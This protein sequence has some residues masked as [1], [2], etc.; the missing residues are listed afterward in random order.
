[1]NK[2]FKKN[3]SIIFILCSIMLCIFCSCNSEEISKNKLRDLDFT[4]VEQEDIPEELIK[5]IDEK[6]ENPFKLSYANSNYLYIVE[7]YGKQ[8]TGGYSIQ[9]NELYETDNAIYIHT[10]L[11]G[12]SK[13]EQIEQA[14]TYPYVVAKI[15][16]LEKN[17]VFE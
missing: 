13:D 17:V 10:T 5:I 3:T 6:K 8:Q 1:M 15:E 11:L 4:V 9:I 16:F 12:P 7:G 14:I 2:L